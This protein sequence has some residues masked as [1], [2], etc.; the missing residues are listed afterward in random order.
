VA[1]RRQLPIFQLTIGL[2]F[3]LYRPNILIVFANFGEIKC[4]YVV[5]VDTTRN[6]S[7]VTEYN[8]YSLSVPN[9]KSLYAI[10]I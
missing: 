3:C 7:S 2:V 4:V 6:W 1:I 5:F 9:Y 8:F 10:S